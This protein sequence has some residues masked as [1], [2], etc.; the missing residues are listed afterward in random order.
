MV[1]GL[2]GCREC[3]GPGMAALKEARALPSSSC[4]SRV[5]LSDIPACPGCRVGPAL[6]KTT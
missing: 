6:S 5:T 1:W 3:A 2:R 4:G